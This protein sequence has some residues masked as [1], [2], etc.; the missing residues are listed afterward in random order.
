MECRLRTAESFRGGVEPAWTSDKA[1][2]RKSAG[3]PICMLES[4]ELLFGDGPGAVAVVFDFIIFGNAVGRLALVICS[5]ALSLVMLNSPPFMV[6][7]SVGS[8]LTTALPEAVLN[9][10]PSMTRVPL[11]L[12]GTSA[13]E[14]ATRKGWSFRCIVPLKKISFF[15]RRI[16]RKLT[17]CCLRTVLLTIYRSLRGFEVPATAIQKQQPM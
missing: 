6:S 16:N 9:V 14:K 15:Q 3:V 2:P 12:P 10:P 5:A 7:T 4:G 11:R 8:F 13:N 17:V 1:P